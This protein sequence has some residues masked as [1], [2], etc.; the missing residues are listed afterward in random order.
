MGR[1]IITSIASSM[2]SQASSNS[3]GHNNNHE[4]DIRLL[5]TEASLNHLCNLT[6]HRYVLTLSFVLNKKHPFPL[7]NHLHINIIIQI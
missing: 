5:K 2:I 6:P 1:K 4:H 7:L 3:N